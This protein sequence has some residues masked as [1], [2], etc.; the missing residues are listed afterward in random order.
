MIDIAYGLQNWFCEAYIILYPRLYNDYF[1]IA[2]T[3]FCFSSPSITNRILCALGIH[4]HRAQIYS[5]IDTVLYLFSIAEK[6]FC[7]DLYKYMDL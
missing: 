1:N 3:T 7:S 4:Y 5:T 2:C 6:F